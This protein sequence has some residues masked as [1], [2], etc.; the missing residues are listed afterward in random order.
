MM[1][2]PAFEDRLLDYTELSRA[3]RTAVDR[4]LDSCQNCREYLAT[5]E[6]MDLSLTAALAPASLS[7]VF[8][9]RVRTHMPA[10][11]GP[12]ML[13]EL[14]D[15]AGWSAIVTILSLIA[16]YWYAP[17]ILILG[18]VATVCVAVA[19][20]VTLRSHADLRE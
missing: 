20:A 10:P 19:V 5:L 11:A 6:R 8:A 3:D 13:P 1:H 7:P 12:G 17:S 15:L 9:A 14:L 2:C 4:H 16:L 18:T